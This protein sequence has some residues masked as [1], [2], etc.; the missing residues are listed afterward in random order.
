MLEDYGLPESSFV[1]YCDNMSAIDISKDPDKHFRTKHIDIRHHFI[2]DLVE[3]NILTLEFVTT[4][5]HT[6]HRLGLS[7]TC[8]L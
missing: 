2:R 8:H 1:I 7:E 6:H 3:D 4:C 5:R